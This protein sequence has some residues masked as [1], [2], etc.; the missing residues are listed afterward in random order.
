MGLTVAAWAPKPGSC[1]FV[2][3]PTSPV[4]TQSPSPIEAMTPNV[5]LRIGRPSTTREEQAADRAHEG[6]REAG[7]RAV[8]SSGAR[9]APRRKRPEGSDFRSCEASGGRTR[10]WNDPPVLYGCPL[11]CSGQHGR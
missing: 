1:V 2:A 7:S 10:Y 3:H 5:D 8:V 4:A 6:A 11:G 9:S